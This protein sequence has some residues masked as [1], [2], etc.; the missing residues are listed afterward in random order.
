M[1]CVPIDAVHFDSENIENSNEFKPQR[2]LTE[3]KHK[4]KKCS[5]LSFAVGAHHCIGKSYALMEVKLCSAN[6]FHKYILIKT[7]EIEVTYFF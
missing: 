3:N 4:I 7:K 1:I 6:L 2:F 5:Y